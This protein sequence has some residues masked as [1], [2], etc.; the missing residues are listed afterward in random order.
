MIDSKTQ[1]NWRS[2]RF[3]F[4]DFGHIATSNVSIHFGHIEQ[5]PVYRRTQQFL[6]LSIMLNRRQILKISSLATTSFAV[7]LAYSA[8]K[9]NKGYNIGDTSTSPENM[10]ESSVIITSGCMP[11]EALATK[12]N[13][14]L[15]DVGA[16][17]NAAWAENI[18]V[19]IGKRLYT[20]NT[21]ILVRANCAL[22]G[23]GSGLSFIKSANGFTGNIID[24]LNFS[25]LQRAQSVSVND[26]INPVPRRFV[27]SGF[28]IDGNV[29]N[30]GGVISSDSGYGIRLYGAGYS[31]TDVKLTRIPG[32]GFYSELAPHGTYFNSDKNEIKSFSPTDEY[33]GVGIR[34]LYI[35]DTGEEGFVFI[36]PADINVS[37]VFVG[38]AANSQRN[39]YAPGKKSKL[40]SGRSVDSVVILRSCEIGFIHAFD[41]RNGHGIYIDRQGAGKP[42]VRFNANHVMSENCFGNIY[43][44][45]DVHYQISTIDSHNNTGG[46]GSRPH[47][48]VSSTVGGV[49]NNIKIKKE[50]SYLSEYGCD[51]AIVNGAKHNLKIFI[52][53]T[54]GQQR[55]RGVLCSS[56]ISDIEVHASGMKG[57]AYSGCSVSY[58]AEVTSQFTGSKL[59]VIAQL[60]E[61]G[62]NFSSS[63]NS[64]DYGSEFEIISDECTTPINGLSSLSSRQTRFVRA[65]HLTGSG[66]S[67]RSEYSS[68]VAVNLDSTE[69][70]SLELEHGLIA[71]PKLENCRPYLTGNSGMPY[72]MPN[73]EQMYVCATDSKTVTVKVKF[74]VGGTGSASLCVDARI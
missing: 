45:P 57:M 33:G 4:S 63:P 74:A 30:Y 46:D 39:E 61:G 20:T 29:Q 58:A 23:V 16:I 31:V 3:L 28:T 9:T 67:L 7:P 70:Q 62:I 71:A 42:A 15:D 21:S 55:G 52:D 19:L 27:L 56:R 68:F 12:F 6:R 36:G 41:N 49:C 5:Q 40:F 1:K 26:T 17:V 48:H 51:A 22:I 60:C 14:P 53:T 66:P 38:W 35:F 54:T 73:I 69:I 43:I 64:G 10:I 72:T 47:L 50:A 24:T 37:D 8:S 65:T 2:I 34:G 32:I 59:K 11:V 44:G 18:G 13:L 25:A